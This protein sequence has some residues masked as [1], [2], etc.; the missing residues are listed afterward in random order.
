MFV[1]L[2]VV[3]NLQGYVDL[4]EKSSKQEVGEAK[5]VF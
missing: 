3:L 2:T 1:E 4:G 5:S